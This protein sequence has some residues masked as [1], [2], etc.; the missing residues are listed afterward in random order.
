LGSVFGTGFF[1]HHAR[2]VAQ[3]IRR[4]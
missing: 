3:R 4:L 1:G 2:T